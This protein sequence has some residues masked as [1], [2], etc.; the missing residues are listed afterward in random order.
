[1]KTFIL[2]SQMQR[3]EGLRMMRRKKMLDLTG[4]LVYNI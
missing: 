2:F 3:R 4:V 1:M